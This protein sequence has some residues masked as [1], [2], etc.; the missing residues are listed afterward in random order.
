MKL[1]KMNKGNLM[2]LGLLIYMVFMSNFIWVIIDLFNLPVTLVGILMLS[3]IFMF[4]VPFAVYVLFSKRKLAD[5]IPLTP[6]DGKNLRYV[7][8]ITLVAMP[9]IAFISALGS[10]FSNN[11][12]QD[13]LGNLMSYPFWVGMIAIG[14][15]PSFFEEV[16]F[17][18]AIYTEHEKSFSPLTVALV[19][20]LFFGIMHMNIQ[21]FLYAAVIGVLFSY[22][23]HYTKS[24]IAP[25]LSHFIINGLNVTLMYVVMMQDI[26]EYEVYLAEEISPWVT[27][28]AAGVVAILMVPLFLFLVKKFVAHNKKEEVV[29]ENTRSFVKMLD[30]PFFLI[31][32]IFL[33]FA[34]IL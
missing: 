25:M 27:V 26:S 8:G 18:G 28:G 20:G 11:Y 7:V 21:Q 32:A 29:T 2:M 19:N 6:L 31:L 24:L 9:I 13:V 5:I 23:R 4:G 12:V 30:L 15:F 34:V 1:K 3:Q 22:F 14:M 16:M 33:V 10:T 17:R